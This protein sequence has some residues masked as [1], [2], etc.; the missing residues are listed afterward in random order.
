[1]TDDEIS[2]AARDAFTHG[3]GFMRDGKHVPMENVYMSAKD[4]ATDDLVKRLREYCDGNFIPCL[5]NDLM[6][7]AAN[8]IEAQDKRNK[9]LEA[10]LRLGVDMREKQKAY[11]KRRFQDV[12]LDCKKAER[13][14]DVSALAALGE[15]KDG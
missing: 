4:A 7:A 13:D 9:E 6:D 3:T 2:K 5:V 14:F 11:F 1:M 8:R 10:A 12:L 15:K